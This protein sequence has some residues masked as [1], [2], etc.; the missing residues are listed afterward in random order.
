MNDPENLRVEVP[1]ISGRLVPGGPRS[2]RACILAAAAAFLIIAGCGGESAE[3]SEPENGESY[4]LIVETCGGLWG[5]PE[6]IEFE[7]TWVE[8]VDYQYVLKRGFS[9][10]VVRLDGVT[11][12]DSGSF[13]MDRDHTLLAMC[14]KR[15]LWSLALEKE[16]YYCCP[17]VGDDGT[18]YVTT[19]I[20]GRTEWGSVY[21]VNPDGTIE[22]SYDLEGNACS[23][24]V[25]PDGTIYVQDRRNIVY[26]L[27]ESGTL[28]WRFDDFASPEHPLYPVGQKV[29]AIGADGTV[30]IAADGLYALDPDTGDSLWHF[31]PNPWQSCRQA[32]VIGADGTIYLTIHQHDLYAVNPDGSERWHSQFDYAQE[33]SFT[34]PA[35][36][37]DGTIYI[38]VEAT[39][40]VAGSA[41]WAFNPDGTVKWKYHLSTPY[42]HIRGSPTV[43]A[44]GTVYIGVKACPGTIGRV[45]AFNNVGSPVWEY[46]VDKP[47][48]EAGLDDVYST[49]T[50]GADSLI[51]V[52]AETGYFYC[53]NPDGTLNWLTSLGGINWSS[54]TILDDGTL[55][56]GTHNNNPGPHGY[57][58]ALETTSRGYADSPW[59]CYRHDNKN[60]GRYGGP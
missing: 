15:A 44:D 32:P 41:L 21:A 24:A 40:E 11:V 16:I 1:S 59:P 47:E 2:L 18:I 33:Q 17:A 25:G 7:Y 5:Y 4:L 19:G 13:V 49:P 14:E 43:G 26:A 12:P 52:G 53:L 51:Y 39:G 46:Y 38:G 3:T 8:T 45:V 31:N 34:S 57:F 56:I 58:Y 35:I 10:L 42:C 48:G 30:Y 54:A 50:V 29:P 27:L 60:T 55:Y 23:P 9:D 28:K 22:W 20:Y 6:D 37:A 36:D